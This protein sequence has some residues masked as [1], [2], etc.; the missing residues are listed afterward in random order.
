MGHGEYAVVLKHRCTVQ[1][2]GYIP[3]QVEV[4]ELGTCV[5]TWDMFDA[6]VVAPLSAVIN[7]DWRDFFP[8][9]RWIPNRS[10][11]DLVRTVDFKRNSIMKALIRAQ[12][13]R[14]ANLK[15]TSLKRRIATSPL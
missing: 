10:V 2:F 14:L 5:S 13:M 12:R 9:L 4:P 15:V 6:L 7:V 8:A 1:V 11:E 3:D